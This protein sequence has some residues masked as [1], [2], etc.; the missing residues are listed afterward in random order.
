M[1]TPTP[2]PRLKY[3][4]RLATVGAASAALMTLG[5]ASAAVSIVNV[6]L[7]QP[8]GSGFFSFSAVGPSFTGTYDTSY[9]AGIRNCGLNLLN[10]S[11]SNFQWTSTL[12]GPGSVVG[13]SQSY[14]ASPGTFLPYPADGQTVYA[15]YRLTNQ[16]PGNDETYYGYIQ[17][18]GNPGDGFTVD[19]YTYESTANTAITVVPEVSSFLLGAMGVGS[20]ALRRRR[21]AR[22]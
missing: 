17:V 15:G 21:S 5:T 4:K 9:T 2:A 18:T 10:F 13:S 14:S 8:Y 1:N 22:D 3:S 7:F 6:D 19:T 20:L 16:G 12:L 11:T